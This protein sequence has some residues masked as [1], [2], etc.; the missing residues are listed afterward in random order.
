MSYKIIFID[1][2]VGRSIVQKFLD[3][4]SHSLTVKIVR[5]LQYLEEFGITR[6]NPHLKKLTNTQFWEIRILG[7]QNVRILCSSCLNSQIIVVHMFTKRTSKT[8]GQEINKATKLLA[9][10]LAI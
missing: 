10:A 3:S 9:E 7:K 4:C 6:E 1:D 8:P 2:I 5:Q